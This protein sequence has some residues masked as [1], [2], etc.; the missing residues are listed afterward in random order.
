MSMY[1]VFKIVIFIFSLIL[2]VNIILLW[3]PNYGSYPPH[4]GVGYNISVFDADAYIIV[5]SRFPPGT[6]SSSISGD[7]TL[8]REG[9]ERNAAP[10]IDNMFFDYFIM[11]T[12]LNIEYPEQTIL[13]APIAIYKYSIVITSIILIVSIIGYYIYK[14][15][16]YLHANKEETV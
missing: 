2:L 13:R 1:S 8:I 15:L 16:N 12:K 9:L 10:Y 7:I 5:I 4:Y 6:Y 14:R 3:P 11:I